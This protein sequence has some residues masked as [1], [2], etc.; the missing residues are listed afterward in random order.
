MSWPPSGYV[1]SRSTAHWCLGQ[2]DLSGTGANHLH[3]IGGV[4]GLGEADRDAGEY[5]LRN[6]PIRGVTGVD[7][8]RRQ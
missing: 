3:H 7:G 8:Q 6:R 1:T 4:I 5:A 2:P